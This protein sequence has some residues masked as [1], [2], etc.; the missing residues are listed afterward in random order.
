MK[1]LKQ[2][3]LMLLII[4]GLNWGV[5]GLSGI[6]IVQNI[7][8]FA[9]M[10]VRII[11]VLVGLSALYI[12]FVHFYKK[13]CHCGCGCHCHSGCTCCSENKT[14]TTC[15]CKSK[16]DSNPKKTTDTQIES[17]EKQVEAKIE[18]EIEE[19]IKIES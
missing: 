4:G 7:F 18:K 17:K 9:P 13:T 8:G 2:K 5:Y 3:A 19:E 1:I 16:C 12:I 14:C 11:Y 15:E 10:I 6:N